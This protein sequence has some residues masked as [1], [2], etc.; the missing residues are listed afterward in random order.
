MENNGPATQDKAAANMDFWIKQ[1]PLLYLLVVLIL[2]GHGFDFMASTSLRDD[3]HA[4]GKQ[5][6]EAMGRLDDEERLSAMFRREI[7]L[8][9][10]RITD[11]ESRMRSL[12]D[13]RDPRR[14]PSNPEKSYAPR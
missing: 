7:D 8:L 6:D 14:Y 2:G 3:V 5:L 13:E 4:V 9:D 11:L 1:N 12:E 10:R